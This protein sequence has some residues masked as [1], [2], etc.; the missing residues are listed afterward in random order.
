MSGAPRDAAVLQQIR[1]TVPELNPAMARVA[2]VILADPQQAASATI[3]ALATAAETSATAVTRFA[4]R[5]GYAGYP[6]LRSAIAMDTGRGV[7]SGWERDI[8]LAISPT[9]PA[10]EVLDILAG[11]QARALRDAVRLIDVSAVQSAASAI[12]GAQRVHIHADWADAVPAEEMYLRLL[13]IGIPIWSLGSDLASL[14]AMTPLLSPGDVAIA[15]NR[16]GSSQ[17]LLDAVSRAGEQGATTIA[18]HGDPRSPLAEA[19]TIP[20]FTGI[21]DGTVWTQ[22]YA[23][24]AS[25]SLLGSLLWVLVAQQTPSRNDPI[26][27]LRGEERAP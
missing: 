26:D 10:A 6:A 9:D 3:T 2:R 17:A 15:L 4:A 25:D 1:N 23:G 24:R 7:Q 12:A 21:Q 8:G 13:R 19:S 27:V 18:I 11:T 16:S 22:Y 5:L 14:S 20:L